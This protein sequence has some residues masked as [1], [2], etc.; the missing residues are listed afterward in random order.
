MRLVELHKY[1]L[2]LR[3]EAGCILLRLV[4]LGNL[5]C[6]PQLLHHLGLINVHNTPAAPERRCGRSRLCPCF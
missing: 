5:F 6:L 2:H 1:C 4:L 3:R